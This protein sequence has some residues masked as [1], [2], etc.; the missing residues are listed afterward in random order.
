MT[1]Y[2]CADEAFTISAWRDPTDTSSISSTGS[3]SAGISDNSVSDLEVPIKTVQVTVTAPPSGPSSTA[4][5]GTAPT[6]VALGDQDKDDNEDPEP[7]KKKGSGIGA[8]VGGAVGGV[9]GL[10]LIGVLIWWLRRKKTNDAAAAA[11]AP[12][13]PGTPAPGVTEYKPVA[14][15]DPSQPQQY[16][17]AP[18]PA[19]APGAGGYYNQESGDMPKAW[20]HMAPSPQGTP[21]PQY[22][23]LAPVEVAGSQVQPV[24]PVQQQQ[25]GNAHG[26]VYEAP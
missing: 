4:D 24:V 12:A 11:A 6:D 22:P 5:T 10:A 20:A 21:T 8:I 15:Y 2:G 17:P 16:S 7:K 23:G 25:P 1:E 9:I 14:T 26:P 3:N 13:F 19:A 18:P